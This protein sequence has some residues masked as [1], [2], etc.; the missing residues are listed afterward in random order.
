MLEKY[1]KQ[2]WEELAQVIECYDLYAQPVQLFYDYQE[3]LDA[4]FNN[5]LDWLNN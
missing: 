4:G 5:Y 1:S 2:D 3:M